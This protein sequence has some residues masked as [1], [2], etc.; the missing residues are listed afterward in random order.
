MKI[1]HEKLNDGTPFTTIRLGIDEM[2]VLLKLI[3]N[4]LMHTPKG[5]MNEPLRNRMKSMERELLKGIELYHK[6]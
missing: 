4:S 2:N 1:E 5:L 6:S 3:Q